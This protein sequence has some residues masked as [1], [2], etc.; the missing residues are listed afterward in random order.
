MRSS[1]AL[2]PDPR[3]QRQVARSRPRPRR[4]RSPPE[5]RLSRREHRRLP[6]LQ[7]AHVDLRRKVRRIAGE[8]VRPLRPLGVELRRQPRRVDGAPVHRYAGRRAQQFERLGRRQRVEVVA[9]QPR[10]PAA[11]GQHG[12][13]D[14]R[15]VA[16]AVVQAGVAGE[17]GAEPA[18]D[19][20]AQRRRLRARADSGC[21]R[22]PP[23]LP[24][25]ARAR[26]QLRRPL[27]PGRPPPRP[28][29]PSRSARTRAA[30]AGARRRAAPR[31]ACA[32]RS[33]A[34]TARPG[35]RGARAR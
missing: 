33:A 7:D 20:V 11:D 22:D 28:P 4:A 12:D 26:G 15:Q 25:R 8:R 35:G 23:G 16:H 29:P 13:V 10:A 27:S 18:G 9:G 31:P 24:S 3:S 6:R 17:V 19:D 32:G 5:P 34:A 1:A 2:T 30:A 21:P 14:R